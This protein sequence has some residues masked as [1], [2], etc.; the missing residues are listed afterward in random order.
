MPDR[1]NPGAVVGAM[2]PANSKRRRFLGVE[3]WI[4]IKSQRG[5]GCTQSPAERE[6]ILV[7]TKAW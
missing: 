7:N 3:F 5:F 4:I 1:T 6:T 2:A